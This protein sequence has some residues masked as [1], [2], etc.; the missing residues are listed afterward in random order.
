MVGLCLI[1]KR[2]DLE[3]LMSEDKNN[4]DC[5]A[6]SKQRPMGSRKEEGTI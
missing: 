6:A 5:A 2:V 3:V 4:R 1:L